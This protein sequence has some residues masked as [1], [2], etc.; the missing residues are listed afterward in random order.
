MVLIDLA[1]GM[2]E[3]EAPGELYQIAVSIDGAKA[4]AA[5][6]ARLDAIGWR[7][8]W[9]RGALIAGLYTDHDLAMT[10]IEDTLPHAKDPALLADVAAGLARP[11]DRDAIPRMLAATTNRRALHRL[12]AASLFLELNNASA[13]DALFDGLTSRD[14]ALRADALAHFT[15][16]RIPRAHAARFLVVFEHE[17]ARRPIDDDLA[18][19]LVV[20]G[21]TDR[22]PFD[23]LFG[24]LASEDEDVRATA[25]HEA[26]G[27]GHYVA[28][29]LRGELATLVEDALAI[30]TQRATRH[31]LSRALADLA[32]PR[33]W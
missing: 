9:R 13:F 10:W 15:P 4:F 31:R 12:A 20:L 30:T 14:P 33:Y 7:D 23:H 25:A 6:T 24:G 18:H 29:P 19:T 11:V 22:R 16:E 32:K 2:G 27:Y 21:S 26:K 28:E 3:S 1:D 8:T 17:L 5:I